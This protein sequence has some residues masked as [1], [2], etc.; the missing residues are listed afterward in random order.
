M[1]HDVTISSDKLDAIKQDVYAGLNLDL[2]SL[3]DKTLESF[4][5]HI[6]SIESSLTLLGSSMK[7]LES[8]FRPIQSNLARL[9]DRFEQQALS[10]QII[11]FGMKD[12]SIETLK[13]DL[14]H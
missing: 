11:V 12:A 10:N 4:N 2:R 8:S 3:V 5:K 1:Q 13:V 9:N 14:C 6:F 7:D